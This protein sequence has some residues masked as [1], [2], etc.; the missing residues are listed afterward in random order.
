MKTIKL[1]MV[2]LALMVTL[3]VVGQRRPHVKRQK[4]IFKS[5]KDTT[6]VKVESYTISPNTTK[7]EP[8]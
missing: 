4:L 1:A 8:R 2:M 7:I 3:P 5:A 6:G